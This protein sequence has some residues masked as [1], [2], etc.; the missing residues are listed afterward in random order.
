M[1]KKFLGSIITALLIVFMFSSTVSAA[2]LSSTDIKSL[3]NSTNFSIEREIAKTQAQ[4]DILSRKYEIITEMLQK[5][6]QLLP[7]GSKAYSNI[8][9]QIEDAKLNYD[10]ELDKLINTLVQNTNAMA[11]ETIRIAEENGYTVICEMVEVQ[12]GDR[13]VL[14]DPL[15]VSDI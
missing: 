3:V 12:I 11:S 15:R 7:A 4:A 6:Q 14:I 1:M 8:S 9:K 13:I 2:Q 10:F 5:T